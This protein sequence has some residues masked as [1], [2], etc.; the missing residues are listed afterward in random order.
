MSILGGDEEEEE[1][2]STDMGW[3]LNEREKEGGCVDEY[4]HAGRQTTALVH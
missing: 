4:A 2:E 3:W 1:E